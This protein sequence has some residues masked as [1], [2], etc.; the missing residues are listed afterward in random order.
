MKNLNVLILA[1]ILLTSCKVSRIAWHTPSGDTAA[2]VDY[3]AEYIRENPPQNFTADTV[4]S[5]I[6]HGGDTSKADNGSSIEEVPKKGYAKVKIIFGTDRNINLVNN[7]EQG[8]GGDIAN[9]PIV[10]YVGYTIVTIP[11]DHQE[12]EIDKP[13][14][15]KLQF[16]STPKNSMLEK[17]I[18]LLSDKAFD[19]L[20]KGCSADKDAFIFI[21]GF[22]STFEDAALRTAQLCRD[23]DYP[24]TPIMY[25]WASNGKVKDYEKDGINVNL[26]TAA[27]VNFLKEVAAQG[28]YK[29]LH[30]IAHSM[31][32]RLLATSMSA[33]STDPELKKLKI[34][35]IVMAAPDIDTITFQ[36]LYARPLSV[37]ANMITVYSAKND[38][39]LKASNII[40]GYLRVGQCGKPPLY[41]MAKN[42]DFIDAANVKT[43]FLG[44]DRFAQSTTIIDDMTLLLETD[45]SPAERKVPDEK[46]QNRDYF[47]FNKEKTAWYHDL[48]YFFDNL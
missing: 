24:M 14:L 8:F 36:R 5:Y 25:S 29:R 33:L 13:H 37:C 18:V 42:I 20:L 2:R 16:K 41:N 9:L 34:D 12:G 26:A 1:L 44:H 4:K 7:K 39:A 35:E 38:W 40:G 46:Y 30:I 48:Y 28:N 6:S 45:K 11:D 47:Y 21:H 15:L 23:I 31:G 27:F 32:N 10:N 43:D 19:R 22:N 17:S 3:E